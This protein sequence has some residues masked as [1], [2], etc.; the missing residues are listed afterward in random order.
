MSPKHPHCVAIEADLVAAATGDADP[1]A[2]ARVNDHVARCRPCR[3]EFGRYRAIDGLVAGL[4]AEPD[5][6][7]REALAREALAAR[8]A[9]LRRRL[10]VYR[11]FPSPLGNLLIA[12]SELGVA[13]VE[14]LG[15]ATSVGASRLSRLPG[16]DATEDGAEVEALYHDVLD[17]LAGRRAGLDWSLDLTLARGDFDRRVLAA[18]SEIPYGAVTSYAA[19]AR[20]LGKA[21]AARAVAQALRWNPLPIVI[22]CHRVVGTSGALTGYAGSRV[23][24]KQQLLSIEGIRMTTTPERDLRIARGAMYL[25][26]QGDREY[27]LPTCGSLSERSLAE[28]L[29][30]G[31][32]E[33]AEAAG[34]RPCTAC[35]P[36]VNPLPA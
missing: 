5:D 16:L 7:E 27:C 18:T 24:L 15:Q 30:F 20:T 32:R 17:Y 34:F 35:R 10:L 3:D 26:V 6:L 8:L 33:R 28:L 23:G 31:T 9:D 2:A 19:L 12:R 13:L 36:D 1:A 4:R 22:P 25:S 21:S 29:V 14:Y 11:I